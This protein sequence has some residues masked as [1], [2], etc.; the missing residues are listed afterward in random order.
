VFTDEWTNYYSLLFNHFDPDD[1]I[2]AI[3][4]RTSAVFHGDSGI[5]E[6]N[7]ASMFWEDVKSGKVR[8]RIFAYGRGLGKGVYSAK[9]TVNF[10]KTVVTDPKQ[11]WEDLKK[12][13]GSVKSLWE[14]RGE[15]WNKFVNASPEEQAEMIGE[16]FGQVEFA[17]ASSAAG[18][19]A[20]Q[21]LAKLGELSGVVGGVARVVNTGDAQALLFL[22]RC[23]RRV[24]RDR[25]AS[26][27]SFREVLEPL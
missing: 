14:H 11:A 19:A 7:F 26:R 16:L 20:T 25:G 27:S 18:G 1:D 15:L 2:A 23:R 4:D 6:L 5:K 12:M 24:A 10:V 21:G 22:R 17:I 3:R 13:P 8:D 9:G